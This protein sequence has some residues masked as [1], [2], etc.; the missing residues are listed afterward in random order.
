MS[1]PSTLL[2]TGSVETS[3][4][5]LACKEKS[6]DDSFVSRLCRRYPRGATVYVA[7]PGRSIPRLRSERQKTSI[8]HSSEGES[9]ARGLLCIQIPIMDP[10][11]AAQDFP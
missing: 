9:F 3:L 7:H 11:K 2:R 6:R 10:N 4:D 8:P 5:S 1:S